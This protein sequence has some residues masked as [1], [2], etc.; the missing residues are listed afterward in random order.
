MFNF[1]FQERLWKW[2]S[3]SMHACPASHN[4]ATVDHDLV[5]EVDRQEHWEHLLSSICILCD[6]RNGW[7]RQ[8]NRSDCFKLNT[9]CT[10]FFFFLIHFMTLLPCAF[11][12]VDQGYVKVNN[13]SAN[14]CLKRICIQRLF[15]QY[16]CGL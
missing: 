6:R 4:L 5:L 14:R 13:N 12:V 9:I 1:S 8:M 16:S 15:S 3:H 11:C 2:V 7:C 10:S